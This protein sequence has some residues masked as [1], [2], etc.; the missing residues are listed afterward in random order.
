MYADVYKHDRG[1]HN[2]KNKQI[3]TTAKLKPSTSTQS[4][5]IIVIIQLKC[6]PRFTCVHI[7][8]DKDT[9]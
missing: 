2:G 5:H 9:C 3:Q 1:K 8:V 6:V 4:S 7:S